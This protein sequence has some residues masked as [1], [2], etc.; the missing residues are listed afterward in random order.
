[1]TNKTQIEEYLPLPNTP[2]WLLFDLSNGHKQSLRYVWWFQTRKEAR[3]YKKHVK[4]NRY[5][6]DLSNPIKYV[7][8]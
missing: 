1:M 5:T 8:Q 4:K 6:A 2:I 3:E 7:A